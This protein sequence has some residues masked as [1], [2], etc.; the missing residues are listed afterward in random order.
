MITLNVTA[1]NN[2]IIKIRFNEKTN[3]VHGSDYGKI[4]STNFKELNNSNGTAD[5]KVGD[6]IIRKYFPTWLNEGHCN[7]Q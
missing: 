2:A 4:N 3:K 5:Y 1:I 7:I 6:K